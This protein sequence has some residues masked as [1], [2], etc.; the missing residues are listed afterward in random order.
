MSSARVEWYARFLPQPNTAGRSEQ[1]RGCWG[2]L[3]GLLLTGFVSYLVLD[4]NAIFLIAPMGASAVLVFCQPASPLAQPWS[5]IGGNMVSALIGVACAHWIS[6]TVIAAPLACCLAIAAMFALRCLHPPGGAVA[7]TAVI[8]AP[9]MQHV[10]SAV[11]AGRVPHH[12]GFDYVLLPVGLNSL[13]L[14]AAGLVFNN[15]TG[16]RY[17][18]LL[19]SA[20]HN[21]HETRDVVPTARVGFTSDDLDA[22]LKRYDQVLDVSRDDLESIILETEM[23]AYARR[24]GV[25]TCGEI[26][27]KDVVTLEFG[28]EL[29]EAW[30]LMRRHQVHALPVL[31]RT[32][33]VIGIVS[34]SDFLKHKD[35]DEYKSLGA[36]LRRSLRRTVASRAN[37]PEVVGQIMSHHVKTTRDSMPIVELVPLMANSGLHHIPVVDADYRFLG[38]VTQSD[39]VAALYESRLGETLKLAA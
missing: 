16:R 12:V 19:H 32:R 22:V 35:L 25:I 8:S 34:Q 39:L 23:H 30:R 15:L 5:V 37:Q 18:H 6:A 2:A 24:F 31:N 11:L 33:R 17:P 38:I 13:L 7:L 14:V 21:V 3:A 20:M 10:G 36:R 1:I 26:M 9:M 27:S 28:T 4:N 29:G